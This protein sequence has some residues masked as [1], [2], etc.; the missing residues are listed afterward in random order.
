M[1]VEPTIEERTTA[2]RAAATS[3]ADLL[4]LT[5]RAL[6]EGSVVAGL[7]YWGAEASSNTALSIALAVAA[8]LLGFGVWG[9]VDFHQLDQRAEPLRLLQELVISGLSALGVWVAGQ[10][11]VAVALAALT[12]VYHAAVYASGR[13]LLGMQRPAAQK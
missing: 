10:H 2:S 7:A 8:P 1:A 6:L 3:P 11:A 4:L 13:R 12:L 5:L 9:A